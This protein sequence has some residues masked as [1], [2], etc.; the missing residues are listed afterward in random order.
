MLHERGVTSTTSR[1]ATRTSSGRPSTSTATV[2]ETAQERWEEEAGYS[3]SS[4]A[5]EI[6]GLA[7]AA[8]LALD[9][10]HEADAL[11]WLSLADQWANNVE[12][13]TAT[14]TGTER[15]TNTP[16][17]ARVTLDGTPRWGTSGH[18]PTTARRLTTQHHRRRLPRT[19]PAGHQARR[20]RNYPEL[21]RRSRRHDQRRHAVRPG[22]YRY[23]GDGYGER[24]RD[25]QGAPWSVEHKGKGRLWPLLTGERAEYELHRDD[26][27]IPPENAL[28][29]MQAWRTRDG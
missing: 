6:A 14:E 1:T 11:V 22:F 23:N 16:Y 25:D 7:C 9:T 21:A 27:D 4:I 20:R 5:A 18:S 3:P 10:G 19:R 29:M 8:K 26:P 24:D 17:Y 13:W 28:Q 12:A 2:R 15:H